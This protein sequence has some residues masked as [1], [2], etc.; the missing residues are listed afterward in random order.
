MKE[1]ILRFNEKSR[2][3][4]IQDILDREKKIEDQERQ[5]AELKAKLGKNNALEEHKQFLKAERLAKIKARP[6]SPGQK[7]GHAGV[8]REKPTKI[9]R[10]V[11]Q[12]FNLGQTF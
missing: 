11:E 6:Q 10:I 2:D 5:I 4:L 3:E 8:T 1:Q 9:D 7:A 12:T